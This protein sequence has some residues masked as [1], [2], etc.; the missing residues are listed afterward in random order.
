V[1]SVREA[2]LA[3]LEIRPHSTENAPPTRVPFRSVTSRVEPRSRFS[4]RVIPADVVVP[5]LMSTLLSIRLPLLTNENMVRLVVPL[6]LNSQAMLEAAIVVVA[7]RV[8]ES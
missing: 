1:V 8:K 5:R 4:D 7:E 6:D 2:V 3:V